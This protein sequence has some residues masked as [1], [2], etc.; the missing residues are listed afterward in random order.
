MKR[1]NLLVLPG[2]GI[3]PEVT[4]GAL[5]VLEA[6]CERTDLHVEIQKAEF[7]GA[8]IDAHGVP[9]T[10]DLLKLAKDSHAIL[11]GAVGGPQWDAQ[12]THLRPEKGL[13]Q[14]RKGLGVYA[15]LRPSTFFDALL[16]SSPLKPEVCRGADM[17]I[18]RELVGGIYFG[19][20]RGVEGS[21]DDRE[22][23]NTMRYSAAEIKRV[24]KVA[25]EAAQG[26]DKRLL[27]VD[28]ENVLEVQRL[29]R[30]VV[31]ELASD[32]P[33]V[34]VEH[35]YVDNCAMQLVRR[36]TEF[37]VI[38]TGNMFGDIISDA[39]AALTGSLGMLPSASI[40]D[41][42]GLFEPVH[43]SAPDIAGQGI[44]N[45]LATILSL[46][47]LLRHSGQR[48]DLADAI[49]K[50]VEEV[51]ARGLRTADLAGSTGDSVSNEAMTK[52]V[53][54]SLKFD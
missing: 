21:G 36:P 23:F 14:L 19:E 18:V 11:L 49:E 50:A 37:D 5:K 42:P 20:P 32:Y 2:D 15:N 34:E 8:S 17:L 52:A 25:F 41:G 46:A 45:P 39:A 12:P 16:D 3:G 53:I 43:G 28:K 54:D 40:G 1:L 29:W 6:V 31:D 51:L 47:M 27:S 10:D 4:A 33:D 38:V 35:M 7:G 30:S 26:R 48:D 24:A 44:S 22:G 13:L 9:M